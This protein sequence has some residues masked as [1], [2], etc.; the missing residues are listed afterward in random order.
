MR[1]TAHHIIH[2]YRWP[3]NRNILLKVLTVALFPGRDEAVEIADPMKVLVSTSLLLEKVVDQLI[4]D[5]EPDLLAGVTEDIPWDMYRSYINALLEFMN[6]NILWKVSR[7]VKPL[8]EQTKVFFLSEYQTQVTEVEY[9]I[10]ETIRY[11]RLNC[12]ENA[13]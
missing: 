13:E 8:V 2:T 12:N 5:I 9:M 3:P 10:L 4:D 7:K 6:S 11:R 1:H